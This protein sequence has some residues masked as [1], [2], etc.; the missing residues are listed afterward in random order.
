MNDQNYDYNP[1]KD[2]LIENVP[3]SDDMSSQI[4]NKLKDELSK[5][6]GWFKNKLE[7]K[8]DKIGK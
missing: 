7:S 6:M 1:G 4:K 2:E 5:G 3:E 8:L